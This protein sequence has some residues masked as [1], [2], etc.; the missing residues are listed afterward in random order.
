MF[1]LDT[2]TVIYFFKG[3]GRVQERLLAT[4]PSEIAIPAVVVYE[5]EAGIAQST[6][7][8]KR[9]AQLDELLGILRVLPLDEA[10]AKAAAQ[11]EA[12]LR[13]A[14]KPI[15]PMDTLIAGTALAR[16]ATLVTRNTAE[17]RRV[18]GLSIVDWY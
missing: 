17:F 1:A 12:V 4:P 7:S 14:G 5:L 18:R 15:G 11:A 10:A 13:A 9:R 16:R 6:H 3:T 2:N 8:A